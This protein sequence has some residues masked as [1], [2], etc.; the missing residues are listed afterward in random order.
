MSSFVG[1]TV[2]EPALTA[3]AA[4]LDVVLLNADSRVAICCPIVVSL[5]VWFA[6]NVT[7]YCSV[8]DKALDL[9]KTHRW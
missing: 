1:A 2:V 7:A 4:R 6:I 3:V 5:A 9:I 8:F